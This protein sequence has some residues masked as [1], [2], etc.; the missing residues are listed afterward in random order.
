MQ[1]LDAPARTSLAYPGRFAARVCAAVVLTFAAGLSALAADTPPSVDFDSALTTIRFKIDTLD[2]NRDASAKPNGLLDADEMALVAAVLNRPDFDLSGRGGASHSAA[3]AAYDQAVASA[4]QDAAKLLKA[5]PTTPVVVAGY[6]LLGDASFK[7]FDR[8]TTSFGAPLKGDYGL[9]VAQG[10]FF[11][12]DGDADGDGVSNRDEYAAYRKD[13]REAYVRAALDPTIRPAAPVPAAAPSDA[14]PIVIGIV[15]YP[16]FE[17]LDVFGP[18]EM[19]ANDPSFQVVFI[20]ETAGDVRSAQGAIVK[21]EYGFADTPTLDVL[22]V[23][24]GAGTMAELENPAMLDFIRKQDATTDFTTSVCTGSALLAKAGVLKGRKATSN[25][26]AFSLAVQQ[27][28]SVDWKKKARWVEDGKYF[29]S[30]GVSAGT[31]MALALVARIHGLDHAKA[32]AAS[33]EYRWNPRADDDPFA[34]R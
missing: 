9:A 31:D 29:T 34:V 33:L 23:P 25:K 26:A 2:G 15:L 8:M 22:M 24:G 17:V 18:V 10:R 3:R 28:P 12:A 16:G 11:A 5:Y 21:A 27:D 6:A 14:D 20:A 19:W 13:G 32:L 30:S 1:D 7:A 4:S